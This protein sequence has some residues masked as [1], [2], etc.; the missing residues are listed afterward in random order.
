MYIFIVAKN[1]HVTLLKLASA[2]RQRTESS[3]F[4]KVP[5]YHYTN[6]AAFITIHIRSRLYRRICRSVKSSL[7]CF[8]YYFVFQICHGLA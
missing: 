5:T 7:E 8:I 6:Y 2:F 4:Q 1:M 3:P